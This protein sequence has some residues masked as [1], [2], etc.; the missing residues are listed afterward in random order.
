MNRETIPLHTLDETNTKSHPTRIRARYGQFSGGV[1]K[2]TLAT[3]RQNTVPIHAVKCA[4]VS[5]KAD[6][7]LCGFVQFCDKWHVKCCFF[8]Q[9]MNKNGRFI[10]FFYP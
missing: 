10:A 3:T 2:S 9:K 4:Y 1:F 5:K 8:G 7:I 6:L